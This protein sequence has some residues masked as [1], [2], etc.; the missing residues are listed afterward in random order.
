MGTIVRLKGLQ[1]FTKGGRLYVYHRASGVRLT[2]PHEPGSA[3]FLAA[4][5]AAE[6]SLAKVPQARSAHSLGA[7]I[8]AYLD[9]PEFKRL[10]DR[11]KDDYRHKLEWLKPI[12]AMP[13]K[14]VDSTFVYA[15]RD[16]AFKAHKRRFANYVLSVIKV[17]LERATALGMISSNPAKGVRNI[18]KGTNEPEAN[19]GWTEE[20]VAA[21]MSAAS[22]VLRGPIAMAY[23]FGLR[24]GDILAL[25]PLSIRD[26][27]LTCKTSK[28]GGVVALP[29]PPALQAVL[30]EM[31]KH[32]AITLFANSEGLRWTPD[33]FRTSFFKLRNRLAEAGIIRKELTFHGLRTTFSQRAAV[34]GIDDQ[35]IAD[36]MAH[37]DVETTRGYIRE[38][39]KR[40]NQTAVIL[41]LSGTDSGQTLSTKLSTKPS[42]RKS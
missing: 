11:T 6:E 32:D 20:E 30:D 39:R 16:K 13:L 27:L 8:D 18:R 29:V 41:T 31:P 28:T 36:A 10:R 3:A 2:P 26:G 35:K 38:V 24:Q 21:I 37:K 1:R 19:V 12:E 33:G 9:S 23:H 15:L 22:P 25:S 40:A 5:Q 7:A 42:R 34:A 14:S 4:Y 17:V